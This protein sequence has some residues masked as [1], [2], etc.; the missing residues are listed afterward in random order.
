MDGI[1][2]IRGWYG[3]LRL[4]A[5][6][7]L[8]FILLSSA[9][10]ALLLPVVLMVQEAALRKTAQEKGFSLIRVFAFSS[11]QGVVAGD[12]LSLRALVRSLVRQPGI[13]YAMILG[14]DGRVLMHSQVDRTGELVRDPLSLRALRATEPIVQET[15]SDAGGSLFDFAAPVLLLDER[16][17]V[18]RIGISFENERRILRQTRNTIL[19]L[20]IFTLI[21]GLL[22]V[23]MYVRRLVRPIRALSQGAEAVARGDLERRIPVE[24][25]DEV[26]DLAVAFNSMAD[27]L[28]VRFALDRE[29]SSTL[30]VQTVLTALVRH[31]RESCRGDLAI[32][33][34]RGQEGMAATVAASA[35]A[36]AAGLQSWG[37]LP[38]RGRAGQVLQEGRAWVS[39]APYVV[40]PDEERILAEEKVQA[41][42]LVPISVQQ[43]CVGV[44]AVGRWTDTPF[45][46]DTVDVLQHLADQAAVALANALAYREIALLNLSL[47]AKVA[48]RTRDLS[49]A[50][51]A[52]E[53]S[54]AKLQELDR[55]K[56]DF[57]SNVSHELRTPLTAIR[58]S[59]DNLLDGVTGEISPALHRY[60]TRVKSNTDRLVRLISDLLD[61]S[62]IEAGR[63]ELQR[64]RIAVDEVMQ[65]V[66]EALRPMAA[67][68]DLTLA[69]VPPPEPALAFADGDKLHQILLNLAGNA[70]KFTP[71]GGRVTLSTRLVDS[72]DGE[73]VD[74]SLP[75]RPSTH[76]PVDQSIR[77][78]ETTIQDTGPGIPS[79]E[80]DAIFDKFHQVRRDGQHKTHGTGLGLTIAKSLIELHGGRIW[81]ESEMGKGCRFIF[82]LPT[83]ADAPCLAPP[84]TGRK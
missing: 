69:A 13:R 36:T 70:V 81:V 18:V 32:L 2:R 17:A 43:T 1:N 79:E 27:S 4:Q 24:R 56:S 49:A 64:S 74:S 82:T 62:R 23:E 58:M 10:F 78:V 55:L 8:Q 83:T 73:P 12:F 6:L 76:S 84:V 71:A 33:A 15:P 34:Y 21:G 46:S 11:V 7:T 53:V 16:R 42:V 44:L 40:D 9:L 20:G 50:K 52:L 54:H 68:K 39:P 75:M 57:V 14:L 72:R 65:E 22:W 41:L 63:T 26:G 35:G 19:G 29:L 61:L 47:E 66:L 48:E 37:I 28:R 45:G 59:V 67:E 30:N 60:L 51:A 77:W 80:L 25:Q 38:G 31:A 3:R 5:R